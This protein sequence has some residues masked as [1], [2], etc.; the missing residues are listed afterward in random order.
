MRILFLNP[1]FPPDYTGGAEVSLY[2]TGQGLLKQGVTCQLLSINNRHHANVDEWYHVDYL[3]VHRIHYRTRLPQQDLFDPRI[4]RAVRQAVRSFQPDIVHI[5]NISGASLAPYLAC[6]HE[7]APVVNTLHDLWLL[8]P[9][10]MRYRQD[11]SFCDPVRFPDG[12]RHCF[13]RNQ[14]WAAVPQRRRVFQWCT[15]HV[16]C[17]IS[18]SQALIDRHVEAGYA[19]Q[20]FRL[21]PYGF[22]ETITQAPTHPTIR[23]LTTGAHSHQTLAFAGGGNENKGTQVVLKALPQLLSKLGQLRLIVA[24]GGEERYLAQFRNYAPAVQV[25]GNLPFMDMR[26]LFAS[27]DLTLVPSVWHENSPVVIYENFQMGTPVVGS[28]FGGTPELIDEGK[29]GYT[30]PVGDAGAMAEKILFH[31]AKSS[32]E[33]RQMRQQCVQ[34]VRSKFSLEAH[35]AA[36][37][38]IYE[39]VCGEKGKK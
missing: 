22:A 30:F 12:C 23:Q 15:R 17:F 8:C 32:Y 39:E 36:H 27:A 25:V 31:L 9:N 34:A 1:Y 21:V 20:R 35:L 29:T 24:G 18:P 4:Y 37:R 14:Y 3:P 6:Q 28:H 33:R 7:G 19:P 38:G 2:H 10:N 16:K 5:H 11:G 26:A 13:R